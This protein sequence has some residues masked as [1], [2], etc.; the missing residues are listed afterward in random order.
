MIT[1]MKKNKGWDMARGALASTARRGARE[2]KREFHH[3][4]R[5]NQNQ[6]NHEIVRSTTLVDDDGHLYTDPDL[7]DDFEP[8]HVIDG[9]SAKTK[10]DGAGYGLD[11]VDIVDTRRNHDNLG[12]LLAWAR[13][14]ERQ[15]MEGWS[16]E[17]KYAYFKAV[18]PDTLPG[19]HAL[20]HIEV[21]LD[22][23]PDEYNR[24]WLYSRRS[25]TTTK[26]QFRA[27]LN[28]ILSTP[29]GRA[30]LRQFILDTVPVAGH[31]IEAKNKKRSTV[32]ARDEFG[33]I[34]YHPQRPGAPTWTRTA[35]HI[36]IYI[37]QI[38][39]TTCHECSFLRDD[40]LHTQ[41]AVNTFIDLLW[42]RKYVPRSISLVRDSAHTTFYDVYMYIINTIFA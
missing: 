40:P 39:T 28:R 41:F 24:F 42:G 14:T 12:P 35:M 29:K 1:S 37:P 4:H 23:D 27:A 2:E 5:R 25:T 7:F 18:L 20:D 38:V 19:R 15:K 36:D 13:S 34:R 3:I 9:Y 17:D 33:K 10:K 32:V 31:Y 26:E 6:I 30:E 8:R 16:V 21:S 11:M 22:L